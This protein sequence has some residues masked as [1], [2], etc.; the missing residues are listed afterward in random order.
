MVGV[1]PFGSNI[2][3]QLSSSRKEL[4][5]SKDNF[6]TILVLVLANRIVPG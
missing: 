1:E 2:D 5:A 3:G 6:T 4:P